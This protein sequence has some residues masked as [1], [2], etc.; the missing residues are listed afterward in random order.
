M[1]VR[2]IRTQRFPERGDLTAFLAR[3]LPRLRER[4]VVAVTSKVV[5]LA[6]GRVIAKT[7]AATRERYILQESDWALRTKYV[8]LTI[9]DG[10]VMPSA[11]VDRSNARGKLLLLPQDS[12]RTASR[13]RTVIKRRSRLQELGVLITDSRLLPLRAGVVGI[14]LGYAGF[15]GVRDYR[16]TPDLDGRFTL[17]HSRTDVADARATAAVLEMGEGREQQPL[18]VIT[19]APV[20]FTDRVNRRELW[21]DPTE[22]IYRPIFEQIQRLRFKRKSRRA[23]LPLRR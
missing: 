15:K 12:F 18:A 21:V 7:D 6:E 23:R 9:K 19:G 4:S 11:G 10:T 16:G 20:E 8:W 1:R 2:A 5:A 14:A 3:W 22:D 17:Q 13:I